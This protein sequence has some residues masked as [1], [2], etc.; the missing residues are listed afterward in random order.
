[1]E[2]EGMVASKMMVIEDHNPGVCSAA[3]LHAL[4]TEAILI[5]ASGACFAIKVCCTFWNTKS[6]LW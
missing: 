5:A 4:H 1:M 2:V 6:A 3:S